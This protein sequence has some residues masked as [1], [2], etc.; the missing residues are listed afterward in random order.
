MKKLLAILC[1][2]AILVTSLVNS[3][4]IA[5][6]TSAETEKRFFHSF[7]TPE[8]YE[9][10]KRFVNSAGT[11]ITLSYDET[12]GALKAVPTTP[13]K[14]NH[15]VRIDPEWGA[16]TV[17]VDE[18]PVI[19]VKIK[20]NNVQNPAFGG[21][22]AGTNKAKRP[23]GSTAS[24]FS[25]SFLGGSAKTGDWQLLVFDGTSKVWKQG[26]STT[27]ATFCGTYEAFICSL[28]ANNQT[29]TANDVYW[30]QWAGASLNKTTRKGRFENDEKIHSPFLY[31]FV[32]CFIAVGNPNFCS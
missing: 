2:V 13:G 28:T 10:S 15:Q 19:A 30:I 14:G 1:T 7:A 11:N 5:Q 25:D 23:S 24:V 29:T 16:Q 4:V 3:G 12:E 21:V 20:F 9:A 17:K 31:S 18:Y 22:F 26:D 27:S 8:D 6:I 32:C